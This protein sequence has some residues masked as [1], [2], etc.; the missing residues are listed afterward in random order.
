LAR[1][2]TG[3][4]NISEKVPSA[5]KK[6]ENMVRAMAAV[7]HESLKLLGQALRILSAG[8]KQFADVTT[9]GIFAQAVG[10]FNSDQTS[11]FINRMNRLSTE[12]DAGKLMKVAEA[13]LAANSAMAGKTSTPDLVLG[14]T[15]AQDKQAGTSQTGPGSKQVSDQIIV[16]QGQQ[17]L[18]LLTQLLTETMVVKEE[19][20]R[21]RDNTANTDK[22]T[23]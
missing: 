22:N 3:Y 17:N 19:L 7:P 23:R 6:V 14:Q 12:I 18:E 5:S 9:K 20:R 1:A 21:I 8:L 11:V 16:Q 13:T 10:V 15:T 2:I 4:V